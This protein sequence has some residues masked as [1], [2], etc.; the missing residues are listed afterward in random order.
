MKKVLSAAALLL[1]STSAFAGVVTTSDSF[2]TQGDPLNV[3]IGSLDQTLSIAGFDQSLGTLTNVAVT[4]FGQIDSEGHAT[5]IGAA[6]GRG[7]VELLMFSDWQVNTGAADDYTFAIAG[8]TASPYLQDES[9]PTGT[10]NLSNG[11]TFNFDMTSGELSSQ[12]T[13]VDLSA[14]NQGTAVD[15]NFNTT[16]FSGFKNQASSGTSDFNT[17]ISTGSWGKVEVTYTYDAA[18]VPTPVS[19]PETLALLAFGLV[20]FGLSR[21]NKKAA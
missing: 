12:L 13:N 18:V 17:S 2:G 15:F 20:G 8:M 3:S 4:V 9:A 19:E 11:Q 5:Y 6:T 21:R 16:T 1:A 7:A 14:F 10:Y